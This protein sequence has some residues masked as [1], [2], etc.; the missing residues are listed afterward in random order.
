MAWYG[1]CGYGG[2]YAT[3][4]RFIAM[5][6]TPMKRLLDAIKVSLAGHIQRRVR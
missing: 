1:S 6:A 4:F 3:I 5:L 2:E